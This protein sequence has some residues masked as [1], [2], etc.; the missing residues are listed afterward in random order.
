MPEMTALAGL[1][2]QLAQIM[3]DRRGVDLD[4]WMK[5][6]REAVSPN[7][8]NRVPVGQRYPLDGRSALSE[9]LVDYDPGLFP[10]DQYWVTP[11]I[12]HHRTVRVFL[13][14]PS[15]DVRAPMGRAIYRA[16]HRPI[17]EPCTTE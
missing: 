12:D 2:H 11:R 1:M 8:A 14:G 6:V 4:P 17:A 9:S 15:T 10:P 16:Q 3:T 5:E 13:S 7:S